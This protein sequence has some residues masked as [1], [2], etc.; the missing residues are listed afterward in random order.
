VPKP[1]SGEG[2]LSRFYKSSILRSRELTTERELR[3][4][5]PSEDA[6]L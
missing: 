2:G 6:S 3:L 5:E 1:R 4:G